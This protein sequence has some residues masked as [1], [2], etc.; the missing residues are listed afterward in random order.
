MSATIKVDPAG[1]VWML[2]GRQKAA[3]DPADPLLYGF[4]DPNHDRGMINLAN[5]RHCGVEE[6]LDGIMS[7]R[8]VM[9][10]L[11][12]DI[13]IRTAKQLLERSFQK[14]Y[15]YQSNRSGQYYLRF[16]S[17]HED[18]DHELAKTLQPEIDRIL[19]DDDEYFKLYEVV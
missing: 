11:M 6:L 4:S 5:Q 17:D 16:I 19:K 2:I 18:D 15:V 1:G 7:V 8:P 12:N 3:S 13:R 10:K 9:D 14:A